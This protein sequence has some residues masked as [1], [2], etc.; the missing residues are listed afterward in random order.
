[1]ATDSDF[2][3]FLI[4]DEWTKFYI[5]KVCKSKH[6]HMC[7]CEGSSGIIVL[8]NDECR[9]I[10]GKLVNKFSFTVKFSF[11]TDYQRTKGLLFDRGSAA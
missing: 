3:R 4:V 9:L 11:G 1:M 8:L 5:F 6:V 10:S 2:F 7:I